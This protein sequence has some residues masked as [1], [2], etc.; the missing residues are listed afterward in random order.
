M[1]VAASTLLATIDGSIVNVA[2]PTL[3]AELNTSFNVIQWVA[4][5]YLL[6]IATLT[7]SMGRLGDVVGKKR[8]YVLGIVVILIG[9]VLL[10]MP[11]LRGRS[12]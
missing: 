3:V 10:L 9:L 8:L 12:V 1:S 7:M 5:A 4:L 11:A 2:F 6:A